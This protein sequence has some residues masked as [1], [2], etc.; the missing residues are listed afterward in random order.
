MIARIFFYVLLA[1]SCTACA[2]MA[3]VKT[4]PSLTATQ[5]SPVMNTTTSTATLFK[6]S[7]LTDYPDVTPEELGKR[8]LKLLDS[9]HSVDELSL[10]YVK[11]AMKVP[12]QYTPAKQYTFS[13]YLP[14]SGWYYSFSY[15][16][17]PI[18]YDAPVPQGRKGISLRFDNPEN[19]NADMA[20][21][22]GM[23][24]DAYTTALKNI[25]Y[26]VAPQYDT[27]LGQRGRLLGWIVGRGPSPSGA[28]ITG[29]MEHQSQASEPENKF[30]HACL[31]FMGVSGVTKP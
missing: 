6:H 17:E 7:S 20:P 16:E 30:N 29:I 11:A 8:Y 21:V 9:I 13:I 15:Y 10:D 3:E 28:I 26:S 14:D 19:H 12:L 5:E 27:I 31:K 1:A 24:F 18:H 4:K 23:D 25:G 22:C 2:H